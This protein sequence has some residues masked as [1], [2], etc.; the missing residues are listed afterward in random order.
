MN[1]SNKPKP[2]DHGHDSSAKTFTIDDRVD[3]R[4]GETEG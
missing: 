2:G 4:E 1:D 3:I